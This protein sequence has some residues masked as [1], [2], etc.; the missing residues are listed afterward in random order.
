[1][2]GRADP[3][4]DPASDSALRRRC[5]TAARGPVVCTEGPRTTV[6]RLTA[7]RWLRLVPGA[8]CRNRRQ[9]RTTTGSCVLPLAAT[10]CRTDGY[11]LPHRKWPAAH[12]FP[13]NLFIRAI[14]ASWALMTASASV[15][16]GP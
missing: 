5:L 11:R 8:G 9:L 15:F 1:M 14:S 2:D 6:R 4:P 7:C 12:P 13:S 10:D 16:A 3:D